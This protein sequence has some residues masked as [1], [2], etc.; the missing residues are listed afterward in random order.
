MRYGLGIYWR[1]RYSN[2][3][4]DGHIEVSLWTGHPPFEGVRYAFDKPTQVALIPFTFDLLPDGSQVAWVSGKLPG[5]TF[6]SQALAKF[7]LTFYMDR[8]HQE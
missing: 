1:Y 3:L 6:S 8:A 7:I 2:T 5:R 4:N